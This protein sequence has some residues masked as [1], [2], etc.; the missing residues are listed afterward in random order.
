MNCYYSNLIEGYDTHPVDIE[1]A[2]KDD[3]S[4]DRRNV[5][6]SSSPSIRLSSSSRTFLS[7][8]ST[9]EDFFT[10]S[11]G[12]ISL[13]ALDNSQRFPAAYENP[14]QGPRSRFWDLGVSQDKD[15]LRFV[16]S[17]IS[18]QRTRRDMGRPGMRN[19][20]TR[21]V[22]KGG[23]MLS[24]THGVRQDCRK[25]LHFHPRIRSAQTMFVSI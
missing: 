13:R 22:D 1:R 23:C 20:P 11:S 21:P 24:N 16:E 6:S 8:S 5:P 4:Q 10:P 18:T 9:T 17:H 14:I 15:T 3:F 12:L 7:S 2:L 25:W 19:A